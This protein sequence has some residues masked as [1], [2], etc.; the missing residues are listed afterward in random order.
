MKHFLTFA[1]LLTTLACQT[2]PPVTIPKGATLYRLRFNYTDGS[3]ELSRVLVDYRSARTTANVTINSAVTLPEGDYGV[4]ELQEGA[5]LTIEG[6]VTAQNL[7]INGKNITINVKKDATFTVA[8]SMNMNGKVYATNMGHVNLGGLE[9]QGG[10]NTFLNQ[11][12]VTVSGNVQFTSGGSVFTNCGSLTVGQT[13]SLHSGEYVACNC[14]VLETQ[15]LDING[16]DKV[17]GEG[18]IK[19]NGSA[20]VNGHLTKSSTILYC[21]PTTPKLGDAVATCN[22]TCTPPAMPVR[23][24][25]LTFKGGYVSLYVIENTLLRELIIETSIDGMAWVGKKTVQRLP[26]EG[27]FTVNVNE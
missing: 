11:G 15:G 22:N 6:A 24:R 21:G 17:S 27:W 7:N 14:G 25:G 3:H 1:L 16:T 2:E 20:N 18:F 9:M 10:Q 26:P 13:T 12:T 5:V 23:Y 8:S 4:I 19:V